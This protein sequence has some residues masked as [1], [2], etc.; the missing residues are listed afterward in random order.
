[1]REST[2]TI[3]L[4]AEVYAELESLAAQD[5]ARDA[6]DMIARLV[7]NAQAHKQYPE[8]STS[9]LHRVMDR[10]TDSG[11]SG[12]S[13][14]Y[15]KRVDLEI[16]KMEGATLTLSPETAQQIGLNAELSV[17]ASGDTIILKKI[18]PSRLSEIARR[19]P[20]D[21]EMTLGEINQ[22]VHRHRRSR[23]ARRR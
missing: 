21:P 19:A 22:E 1:M 20:D 10:A 15:D 17:F 16:V 7:T 4:P 2:V 23:H 9:A 14:Q 3:E 12:S 18:T 6:A 13:K 5:K 11:M 8:S